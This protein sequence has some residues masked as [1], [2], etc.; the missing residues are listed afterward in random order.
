MHTVKARIDWLRSNRMQV[1]V[2]PGHVLLLQVGAQ[3]PNAKIFGFTILIS[4]VGTALSLMIG[5]WLGAGVAYVVAGLIYGI[6]VGSPMVR[7]IASP[8][9]IYDENGNIIVKATSRRP[10]IL[11]VRRTGR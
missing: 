8:N 11:P 4:G 3:G 5:T 6:K 2:P 9:D 7:Q 10:G 1:D